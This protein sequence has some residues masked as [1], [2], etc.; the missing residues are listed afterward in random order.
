M[1]K[2]IEKTGRQMSWPVF[3]AKFLVNVLIGYRN[4]YGID[5][6]MP[7]QQ[8]GLLLRLEY[9][10]YITRR[11]LKDYLAEKCREAQNYAVP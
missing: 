2:I 4:R 10:G 11:Q 3:C 7:P 6:I 9:E 1:G 5:R 8:M